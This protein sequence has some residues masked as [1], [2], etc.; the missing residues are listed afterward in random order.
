MKAWIAGASLL[1]VTGVC[2]AKVPA[3]EAAKLGK[4]LTEVGAER[5]G[6]KDGGIPA[7]IGKEAFSPD[8]LTLTHAQLEDLR[9]RLV[10][11][12]QKMIVDPAIITDILAQSQAIMDAEPKKADQ[13]IAV[14]RE[15]MSADPAL[16]A[17]FDKVLAGRGGKSVDGLIAQ[18][19]A[20]KLKLPQIRDDII[21]VIQ[22]LKSRGDEFISRLVQSFD[23]GKVLQIVNLVDNPKTRVLA[24]DMLMKYMPS[25]VKGFLTYQSKA[26]Q[27]TA[28][29]SIKPL[30][31]INAGNLAT[32]ANKLT[33]GHK[34][35]F[36][37]YPGY[38][39][40]V[41][42][43]TRNAF[44]PDPILK[45]TVANATRASLSGSEDVQGAELGFPFPI[46]HSQDRRGSPVEPQAEV[47]RIRRASL[48]QP[49]DRQGRRQ[50]QNQQAGGGCEVQVRQ[51]DGNQRGAEKRHLCLLPAGSAG[52]APR[53]RSGDTG[54]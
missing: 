7:W 51:P 11:D 33:E 54:A 19:Q 35:L 38:K 27:T 4:E 44:F 34:A 15:M 24:N 40:I 6:N 17:D 9:K 41:Y 42:P 10:L 1:L 39:M 43:S 29:D 36:A 37:T 21:A 13:V 32:H 28:L 25:Y 16:K 48:Q 53:R 50:L 46:P 14:V 26:E 18:V 5:A 8:M 47:P 12:I 20:R 3:A 52:T 45:A 31:V 22:S 23:I 2:A 49:G 30:Y